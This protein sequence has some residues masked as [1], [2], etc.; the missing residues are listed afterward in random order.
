L[1][2]ALDNND[3]KAYKVPRYIKE[4]IEWLCKE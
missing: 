2:N 4:A 1:V 3:D